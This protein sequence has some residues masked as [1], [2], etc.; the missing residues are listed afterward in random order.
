MTGLARGLVLDDKVLDVPG[1]D[2]VV[3]DP[4]AW[5]SWDVP[6]DRPDLRRRLGPSRLLGGH[7]TA[8]HPRTGPDA[9]SRLIDAMKA[10]RKDDDGDGV[11]DRDDPLADVSVHFGIAWDGAV[12]QLADLRWATVHMGRTVN[13]ISIGVETMWPGS[14]KQARRLGV[15]GRTERRRIGD[16]SI[17]CLVPSPELLAGWVALAR[18]LTTPQTRSIATS[19]PVAARICGVTR[20]PHSGALEHFMAPNTTKVD[21]AGYLLDELRRDGW[22]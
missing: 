3:R 17:E 6:T 18:L 19:P 21:A 12:Y 5:W 9:A 1:S 10:R 11:I 4:R 15:A 20:P 22:R 13:P 16:R 7:W 14:A 2:V 8:G